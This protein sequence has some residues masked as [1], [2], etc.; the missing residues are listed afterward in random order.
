MKEA[1]EDLR[2]FDLHYCSHC[3]EYWP[4]RIITKKTSPMYGKRD[5]NNN[6][7]KMAK[8]Y[9]EKRKKNPNEKV[10]LLQFSI[11]NDAVPDSIPLGLPGICFILVFFFFF[12][13]QFFI[14]HFILF[15]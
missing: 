7:E 2:E 12:F 13:F 8:K 14:F 1:I 6:C 5:C 15:V 4:S 10:P 9:Q 11:D 3:K